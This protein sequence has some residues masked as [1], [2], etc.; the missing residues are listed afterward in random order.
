MGLLDR[1]NYDPNQ[2]WYT[3][4]IRIAW[5]DRRIKSWTTYLIDSRNHQRT[6]AEYF[7]NKE[8]FDEVERMGWLEKRDD[9]KTLRK[10]I[11]DDQWG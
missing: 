7:A 2:Q 11:L 1:S 9:E 3:N 4:G 6:P 8:Q 5:W 10:A